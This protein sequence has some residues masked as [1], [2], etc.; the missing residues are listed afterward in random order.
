MTSTQA[1]A[2]FGRFVETPDKSEEYLTLHFSPSASARQ[3]RWRNYGLSAD[4]LGD[5]FANFFPGGRL[6]AGALSPRGAIKAAVSFIANELLENAIKYS[7]DQVEDPIVLSLY[8]YE[9]YIL[10]RII[11]Y[12]S[13]STAARYQEFIQ[14]L[15]S[16]EDIDTL[17]TQQMEQTALGSG[18]SCLGLLT[19]IC[20][21]GVE[22]GWQFQPLEHC[23]SMTE[24]TVLAHLGLQ[25]FKPEA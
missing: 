18:E 17:F 15:V 1:T 5:Y 14:T 7:D 23:S 13:C 3:E 22:L 9:D 2:Q 20:D 8:L 6:A 4:F 21:Y 11:N 12:T 25:S 10:F 19:M 16:T 24:V